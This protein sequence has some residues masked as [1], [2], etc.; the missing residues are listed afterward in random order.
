MRPFRIAGVHAVFP[1]VLA[2][3]TLLPAAAPPEVVRLRVPVGRVA[4]WFP[5]GTELKGMSA[6]E[7]ES[8]ARDAAA[9]AGATPPRVLRAS[10]SARWEDGVLVGRSELVIDPPRPGPGVLV[11]EPWTPAID[12][13]AAGSAPVRSD[14]SGRTVLRVEPAGDAVTAVAHWRLRARAGS[15]GRKF[16]L[17]L[18][19]AGAC[20]LKLDLPVGLQPEGPGGLRRG[21]TPADGR[22]RWVFVGS[23]GDCTLLLV[24]TEGKA[25]P[26]DAARLWVEGTTRVDVNESDATWVLDWAVAGGPLAARQLRISL[27]PGLDLVGVGGAGVDDYQAEPAPDGSTRLTVRL[28]GPAGGGALDPSTRVSVRA[29]TRVPSEGRWVVP[30]ARPVG[31]VW[32]GGTTSVRLDPSRVVEA[33]RPLAGRRTSTPPGEAGEGARLDFAADRPAPVAELV[34][35]KPRVDA[36]AEVRGVLLVGRASPRFTCRMTWTFHRGRPL[37]LELDLPRAWTAEGV[38]I[39]GSDDPATWHSE[40]DADGGSRVR[41]VTPPGDWAGRSLVLNVTATSS[42]AGGRGPLALPRVRPVGARVVDEV[43]SARVDPGF[44]LRPTRAR[45]LAWLDPAAHAVPGPAADE[46]RPAI[47]WRW[48]ADDAEGRVDRERSDADRRGSVGLTATV[49]PDRLVIDAR[50]V[51]VSRD[52]TVRSLTLGLTESVADP[53]AWRFLDETTGA[54]LPRVAVPPGAAA[55]AGDLGRGPAWRVDLPHPQRGRVALT[56]HY[57]GRWAGHGRVPLIVLPPALRARGTFLALA[58][59]GVRTSATA[60]GA[61][62]L[63][64]DVTAESLAVEAGQASETASTPARR[65]AHAFAYDTPAARIEVRAEAL[66]PAA[67]GGVIREALLTTRV[68][69]RDGRDRERLTLR[70]APDAMPSLGVTLPPGSV[71]ERVL[72]DGQPVTPTRA[73]DALSIRLGTTSPSRPV[74]VVTLDYRPTRPASADPSV[75]RPVRPEMSMPCLSLAWEVDLP[76]PWAIAGWGPALTPADPSDTRPGLLDRLG[77]GRAAGAWR[78]PARWRRAPARDDPADEML[79]EFG[80][81]LASGRTEETSLGEWLT[82]LDAGRWPVV[83][84]RIAL[85]SSGQGPRSRVVPPRIDAS[86]P[87]TAAESLRPLGLAVEAVGRTLLVTTATEGSSMGRVRPADWATALARAAAWGS[88]A[89]DRFQAVAHWREESAPRVSPAES[90]ESGGGRVVWRGFAAGWPDS[91]AGVR[92]VDRRRD[93]AGAWV[94]ALFVLTL[95]LAVRGLPGPAR[96]AG[97]AALVAFGLLGTA[98]APVGL[99]GAASGLLAGSAALAFFGL[100]ET[101]PGRFRRREGRSAVSSRSGRGRNPAARAVLALAALAAAA[102]WA[103]AEP[104]TPDEPGTP[105]LALLPFEGPPDPSRTPDRVLLRLSDYERLRALAGVSVAEPAATFDAVAAV[106]RVGW[107]GDRRDVVNVETELTLAPLGRGPALWSFPAEEAREIS[108]TL[109]GLD[110]PVR[111]ESGARSASVRID[112]ATGDRTR[113]LTLRRSFAP[114]RG[115]WGESIGVAVNP[116]AAARVEVEGHPA[117]LRVE[118]P[119]ARGRVAGRG[120][121]GVSGGLGPVPRLDVRWSPPGGEASYPSA[122][123]VVGQYLWDALP[124]GDRVRAR[125]TYHD[126]GGTG[127]IRLGLGAGVL[128]RRTTIPGV[129]DVSREGPPG[130]DEW[131]ARIDPPLPDGQTVV[132]DLF[133]PRVETA[134]GDSTRT[135]P[136]VEPLGVDRSSGL[137]A[138]RRPLDWAGRI[139]PADGSV[140]VGDDAFVHAWEDALPDEPLTLSGAVKLP[141][142]SAHAP[143]PRVS[144]GPSPAR[145]RVQPRVSLTVSRGRIDLALDADLTETAGT[146]HEVELA[147]PAGFRVVRVSADGLTDWSAAKAIDS[148]LRLRFD[149]P[150]LHH[151]HVRVEGWVGVPTDPFA[152]GGSATSR[153]V[154]VPWPRWPGQD[155]QAGALTVDCP[156]RSSLVGSPGASAA[157]AP[158]GAANRTTYRVTRPGGLGRLR[159]EVEPPHVA[160]AVRSQL[161]IDPDTTE[162][163]AVL[164]YAVSDGPLDA[165]NLRLPAEWARGASVWLEGVPCVPRTETRRDPETRRETTYWSIRPERP[166]WGTQRLVVRSSVPAPPGEVRSFP[167]LSPLGWGGAVDTSLRIANATLGPIAIEGS[168]GLQ[169]VAPQGAAGDDELSSLTPR[170]AAVTGYHVRKS[171]W[172]LR[173]QRTRTPAQGEGPRARH[174]E[175]V[176]TLAADGSVLGLG[177]YEVGPRSGPFLG[178]ELPE[179]ASPLWASVNG[180]QARPLVAGPGRWLI[181]LAGEPV[182]LVALVWRAGPPAPGRAG[183]GRPIPLPVVGLGQVPVVVTVRSPEGVEVSSPNGRLNASSVDRVELEKADWLGQET[184]DA[185]SGLDRGSRREG[186]NLVAALVRFELL[187]RRAERAAA[188]EPVETPGLREVRSSYASQVARRLRGRLAEAVRT[189]SLEDFEAAARANLGLADDVTGGPFAPTPETPLPVQVRPLGRPHSFHG[190]LDAGGR[191]PWLVWTTDPATAT[192]DRLWLTGLGALQAVAPLLA[193]RL[194]RRRPRARRVGRYALVAGL[195]LTAWWAGPAWLAAGAGFAALGRVT[196]N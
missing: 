101:L 132:V 29:L 126:A 38:E 119:C 127:V 14:D 33:V 56:A 160:V 170:A 80:A 120:G 194:A 53:N 169:P 51:V 103:L 20:E 39:E 191:G 57:E 164:R 22:A 144:T 171:G 7:F 67:P 193:W 68:D 50:V 136:R 55:A 99:R 65:R 25:D 155:E 64:P 182:S 95:G 17:G 118:V 180:A 148:P 4:K 26:P 83:V 192:S 158:P 16:A 109:D 43:W 82:R 77:G 100:G 32:T 37:G 131:V 54:E 167:D 186:E 41:V 105:V 8:L 128:V 24:E 52:E 42:A 145:L 142:P 175:I 3:V 73:G 150:P 107:R 94:T 6:G 104:R 49:A 75:R 21:P 89:S 174:G 159:W 161:T 157:P 116:V 176:C 156:T 129:V 35:R 123:T 183:A 28:R 108:A 11:L 40:D 143:P 114:R 2:F 70:V 10:H 179:D 45:G 137:L 122:G 88:D 124:A 61:R 96:A 117:G 30:A 36:S 9:A 166:V 23:P 79:R 81:R 185:L 47:A 74:V 59:R 102:P 141:P 97:S 177:R 76:E 63:D 181:P 111:V 151:R 92:I 168:P 153:E 48:T 173:V 19:G 133:R 106:H 98:A 140:A 15:G 184:A 125:L 178:V 172:S 130:R 162:W 66:T 44:G 188:L 87:A 58:G 196:R 46:T 110:V 85:A 152:P 187:L 154:D 91:G 115:D 13:S 134:D 190:T 195:T 146:V 60:E 189:E 113:R 18:P 112:P 165:I 121:G 1:A 34:F 163:A 147:C 90:A 71:V 72:R 62:A 78:W 27:D 69:P 84:D 12:A 149:G 86:R 135:A 5:P 31:A 93:A 138:F 139:A